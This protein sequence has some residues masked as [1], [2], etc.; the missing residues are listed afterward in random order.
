MDLFCS[1]CGIS[2]WRRTAEYNRKIRLGQTDFYCDAHRHVKRQKLVRRQCP[3]GSNFIVRAQSNR[4][5]CS[6]SCSASH[7]NTLRRNP[8]HRKVRRDCLSCTK[9]FLCKASSSRK[10]CDSQCQQD[11][12]WKKTCAAIRST[13][14]FASHKEAKR[15]LK[16][17]HGHRCMVCGKRK[18][19]GEPIPLVLDHIDGNAEN[20]AV[21][22]FRLLCCNCDAQTDTYKGRNKG[23]GRHA[24]RERYRLGL[25]Y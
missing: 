13:G 21:P 11:Y 6:R 14:A 18:W 16:Y 8:V 10:F 5:F 22:N 3:C 12:Y 9:T 15:Y 1:T 4:K 20:Y 25:S 19:L 23:N 2:I 7:N 17:L 24:R